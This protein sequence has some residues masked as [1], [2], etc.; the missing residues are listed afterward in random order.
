M[1]IQKMIYTILF[2]T[3]LSVLFVYSEPMINLK[4]FCGFK[5]EEYDNYNKI[6]QTIHRMIYCLFCSSFWIT[7]LLTMNF[8]LAV[9]ISLIA[10]L[11]ENR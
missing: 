7:L 4:R 1:E 3:G 2:Y 6:K 5:E 8:E 9:I 10:Y 11:W